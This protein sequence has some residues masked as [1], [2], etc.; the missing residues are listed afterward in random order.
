MKSEHRMIRATI[1]I[2]KRV[3]ICKLVKKQKRSKTETISQH[4]KEHQRTFNQRITSGN[5]KDMY[6]KKSTHK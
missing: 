4:K 1:T 3:E 5:K 6:K 2:N